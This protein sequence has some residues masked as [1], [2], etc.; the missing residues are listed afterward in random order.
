[1][2][3]A[4]TPYRNALKTISKEIRAFGGNGNIH[5]CII[6]IDFFNHIYVNP[7]DGKIEGLDAAVIVL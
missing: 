5:G 3:A 7:F 6:D 1:M 2:K 4:F